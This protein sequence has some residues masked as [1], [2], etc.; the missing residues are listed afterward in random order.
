MSAKSLQDIIEDRRRSSFVGRL[1][2]TLDFEANLKLEFDDPQR[3]FI[4]AVAGQGGMGKTTLVERYRAITRGE[5]YSTAWSSED[6]HDLVSVIESLMTELPNSFFVELKKKIDD[7]RQARHKLE[8]DSEAPEHLARVIAGAAGRGAVK[9]GR[10]VPGAG[11]ALELVDDEAVGEVAGEVAVFV[12][13]RTKQRSDAELLLNPVEILS[14]LFVR[15]LSRLAEQQPIGLFFDTYEE[16]SHFLEP[17]L[18]RLLAAQ[19]GALPSNFLCAI[20]G[21]SPLASSVWGPYESLIR[22]IELGPLSDVEADEFLRRKGISDE[23]LIEQ[24]IR[25]AN[26]LPILLV[27]MTIGK[28]R[29]VKSDTAVE[30]VLR[31]VPDDLRTMALQM[32]VPRSF[33]RDLAQVVLDRADL[34]HDFDWLVGMPFVTTT[35][36]G[37]KYHPVIRDEFLAFAARESSAEVAALHMRLAKH[38]GQREKEVSAD[39]DMSGVNNLLEQVYH[40]I[41]SATRPTAASEANRFTIQMWDEAPVFCRLWGQ[42]IREGEKDL[43]RGVGEGWGNLWVEAIDEQFKGY[44]QP[45]IDLLTRLLDEGHL[46]NEEKIEALRIRGDLHYEAERYDLALDDVNAAMQIGG[47]RARLL[48]ERSF[49]HLQRQEPERAFTDAEAALIAVSGEEGADGDHYWDLYSRCLST[50]FEP[51]AVM[52]VIRA[53]DG[54]GDRPW[55]LRAIGHAQRN[56]GEISEAIVTYEKLSELSQRAEHDARHE[57][58][59]LLLQKQEPVKGMERYLAALDSDSECPTC[60]RGLSSAAGTAMSRDE[61]EE[62]LLECC[63]DSN[64]PGTRAGRGVALLSIGSKR[65]LREL[66]AAIDENPDQ[67]QYHLW[68]AR[69]YSGTGQQL[70]EA[71]DATEEALRL[72]PQ[73][74]SALVHRGLCRYGLEDFAG[75][76]ADWATVERVAPAE[77]AVIGPCDWGLGHSIIGEYEKAIERFDRADGDNAVAEISY[78]RVV[79]RAQLEDPEVIEEELVRAEMD[80]RESESELVKRYGA[81]GLAALRGDAKL[82]CSEFRAACSVDGHRARGWARND[83]AWNSIRTSAEFR[84]ILGSSS[85]EKAN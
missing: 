28:P 5:G 70:E 60:W 34:G 52:E 46:G 55:G 67:P 2:E 7:Y 38:H 72:R 26:G 61:V 23:A 17:W 75:A 36:E 8:S 66:E 1:S 14:P 59:S 47:K 16:T 54:S 84:E 79:A 22:Q 69:G 65:G 63:A 78:N 50:I 10:R 83:P 68:L 49:V 48:Y 18:G 85:G 64:T 11:I 9:L 82:A 27:S 37:W 30:L 32:A 3:R 13:Q 21:R 39:D 42:A 41:A 25:L 58:A 19:Y 24:M 62:L 53:I 81:G 74:P 57:I 76:I 77:A 12:M 44:E 71:I 15:G 33:D 80:V 31:S 6:D 4:L 40:L 29:A 43:V 20:A 56:L 73:W 45:A 35:P 51:G